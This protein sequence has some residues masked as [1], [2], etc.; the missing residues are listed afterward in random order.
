MLT[1]SGNNVTDTDRGNLSQ[2]CHLL[3]QIIH[4]DHHRGDD[5]FW[6]VWGFFLS[7]FN[8]LKEIYL[9]QVTNAT[10]FYF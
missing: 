4:T 5:L 8:I 7:F 10:L 6:F 9:E 3:P 2:S 1:V